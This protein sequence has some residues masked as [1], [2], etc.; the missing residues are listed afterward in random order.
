MEKHH[1]LLANTYTTQI[2]HAEPQMQKYDINMEKIR[3]KLQELLWQSCFYDAD[4]VYGKYTGWTHLCNTNAEKNLLFCSLF[5]K[6]CLI[7]PDHLFIF[8]LSMY[9]NVITNTIPTWIKK[10]VGA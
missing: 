8:E 7:E 6:G 5:T 4:A 9:L 2:L 10:K 1:T 3:Q